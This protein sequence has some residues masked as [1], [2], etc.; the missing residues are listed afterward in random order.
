LITVFVKG[1]N[2]K[3]VIVRDGGRGHAIER[4]FE[5][6]LMLSIELLIR[7]EYLIIRHRG[8]PSHK[9]AREKARPTLP[10]L[11]DLEAL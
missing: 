1:M 10:Y 11:Q 3:S 7:R 2:I 9:S 5:A 6:V 8:I 4:L